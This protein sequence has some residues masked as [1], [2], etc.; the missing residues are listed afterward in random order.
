MYLIY[1]RLP[2]QQPARLDAGQARQSCAANNS[3]QNRLDLI[4]PMVSKSNG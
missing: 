3:M 4:V 1:L 2:A